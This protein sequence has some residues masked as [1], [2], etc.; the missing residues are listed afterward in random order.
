[1]A[2]V[3]ALP[4]KS[5]PSR[6]HASHGVPDFRLHTLG[7]KAFQDLCLHILQ[8]ELGQTVQVFPP[9][10]DGGRDGAFRGTWTPDGQSAI[11]G[12]FAV[13]CKHSSRTSHS[14]TSSSLGDELAKAKELVRQSLADNYIV[15]TNSSMTATQQEQASQAFQKIGVKNF[16]L[17]DR[18]WIN[19]RIIANQR[20]RLLVPRVYG[21][22]DL[23][24]ILDER[25]YSQARMLFAALESDL[26]KFVPTNAYRKAANAIDRHNFVILIGSPGTGKSA[27]AA[28]LALYAADTWDTQTIQSVDPDDFR[29]HWNPNAPNQLFWID[30]A[31]GST[32]YD[33]YLARRWND[34]LMHLGAAIRH[35]ARIIFTSRDYIFQ[36]AQN[37]IRRGSFPLLWDSQV[38]VDVEELTT[39]ERSQIL[40]NHIRHGNQPKPVRK[41][42]KPYLSAATRATQFS[43][44][45]ARRLGTKEFTRGLSITKDG[46]AS[47]F[48]RPMDYLIEILQRI[49]TDERATLALLFVNG[50]TLKSPV[51][52]SAN[53]QE[54]VARVGG[55]HRMVATTLQSMRNTFTRL[56]DGEPARRWEFQHPTIRDAVRDLIK[57]DDELL[58]IY[59]SGAR[60][61]E[62]FAEVVCGNIDVGG[63]A[64]MVP[65][66]QYPHIIERVIISLNGSQR[67]KNQCYEFLSTRCS[68]TFFRE[69]IK[70]YPS[71]VQDHLSRVSSLATDRS[72]LIVT[73]HRYGLLPESARRA[74]VK[75]SF[76][77]SIETMSAHILS[78]LYRSVITE[79]ECSCFRSRVFYEIVMDL[80]TQFEW[81]SDN[82]PSDPDEIEAFYEDYI[83]EL[84][85][86]ARNID[87]D[88][89]F[90]SADAIIKDEI[91]RI[92]TE[93]IETEVEA[94]LQEAYEY[95]YEADL[96]KYRGRSR[97]ITQP[98]RDIFDD[99]DA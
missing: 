54:T 58:D 83:Y 15:M 93:V 21:L 39:D 33:S 34:N 91:R 42:M 66:D 8:E 38:I 68:E 97:Q 86:F 7:W 43:P 5:V 95:A 94:A 52:F 53:D 10:N 9:G 90:G 18:H 70:P 22:G 13:Q 89:R 23:S 25:A 37:D 56:V 81:I 27:I 19:H 11:S 36:R 41:K 3:E 6:T 35:G 31:F 49:G 99:V 12:S 85:S 92:R 50:G 69:L 96:V 64:V 67:E 29:E 46:V 98:Q 14:I 55:D 78:K 4:I 63:Q 60:T 28:T 48:D 45:V 62:L 77:D 84:K 76:D 26:R 47:F 79:S 57:S 32:Q 80:E 40:Y 44:E 87:G 82:A 1:M 16:L 2:E 24:E 65:Q 59:L 71:F 20:L 73:L 72:K 30:D 75:T 61:T 74:F 88:S 51:R 17:H